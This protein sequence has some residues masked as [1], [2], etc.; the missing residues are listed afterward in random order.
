M[1]L[2]GWPGV[3]F[4]TGTVYTWLFSRPRPSWNCVNSI[5]FVKC[6]LELSIGSM[7]GIF[8][9][10]C[11]KYT[12]LHVTKSEHTHTFPIFSYICTTNL[13]L[14]SGRESI[15]LFMN[16]S[17][18][19][20]SSNLRLSYRF[21]L[22]RS[23]TQPGWHSAISPRHDTPTQLSHLA[24]VP[25]YGNQPWLTNTLICCHFFP[26]GNPTTQTRGT[27]F[28]A[29]R[30]LVRVSRWWWLPQIRDN[31]SGRLRG[32]WMGEILRSLGWWKKFP[33]NQL[34]WS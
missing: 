9:Y 27:W 4:G 29:P 2:P 7:Y 28:L 3:Q 14:V 11:G 20:W 26:S 16:N 17:S 34:R 33:A 22:Y 30:H 18:W 13:L 8:A 12:C 23:G 21:L 24:M 32:D 31:Q 6:G 25:Q 19:T 10:I 15:F 1:L 5:K